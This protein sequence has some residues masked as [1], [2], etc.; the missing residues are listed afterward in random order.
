MGGMFRLA[1]IVLF[2][3]PAAAALAQV[4]AGVP[5]DPKLHPNPIVTW[6]REQDFK[7]ATFAEASR[8]V[9][10]EIMSLS[11]EEGRRELLELAM[12]AQGGPQKVRMMGRD[13]EVT[14]YPVVRQ[15]YVLK[16]GSRFVMYTFR[17]PRALT[18]AEALN[19]AAFSKPRR[20][21]EARFGTTPPPDEIEI[22][23]GPG[24]IFDTDKQ[25]TIYWFELGGGHSVTTDASR[26]E[27]FRVLKD[28]L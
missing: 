20:P 16:S 13:V 23:G 17:F 5:Y 3:L 26:E 7:P 21:S 11:Q 25:L 9:G 18:S 27:L 8:Q 2:V 1:M 24:L 12:P 28:L 10:I 14:F 22:R 4:P 15:T 6:V 19:A